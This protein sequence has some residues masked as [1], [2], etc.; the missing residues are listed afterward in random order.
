MMEARLHRGLRWAA[1]R[2]FVTG[3]V[4]TL[5]AVAYTHFIQPEDLGAYALAALVY[6]GLFLLVQALQ[7]LRDVATGLSFNLCRSG[8]RSLRLPGHLFSGL[9]RDFELLPRSRLDRLGR[10]CVELRV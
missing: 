3:L 10:C 9:G 2:Q 7:P 1:M 4:G 6:G 5:G 8:W